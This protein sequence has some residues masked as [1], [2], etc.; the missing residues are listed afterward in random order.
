[1]VAEGHKFAR[2]IGVRCSFDKRTGLPRSDD[3][4]I[5]PVRADS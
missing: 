2:L 5:Y 4:A 1:M 3:P